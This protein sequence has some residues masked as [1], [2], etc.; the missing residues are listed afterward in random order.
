MIWGKQI[1]SHFKHRYMISLFLYREKRNNRQICLTWKNESITMFVVHCPVYFHPCKQR[2]HYFTS[3]KTLAFCPFY[4]ISRKLLCS[5]R[6]QP[7]LPFLPDGEH[8]S[9]YEALWTV[10]SAKDFPFRNCRLIRKPKYGGGSQHIVAAWYWGESPEF[11]SSV[12][13][14]FTKTW[15]T[16]VFVSRYFSNCCLH[17]SNDILKMSNSLT[18]P[19]PR[20]QGPSRWSEANNRE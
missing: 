7:F 15:P 4:C 5:D 11:N 19:T 12:F 6:F 9:F 18:V 13:C 2:F 16:M 10:W 8:W 20:F 14:A 1:N 17:N 3:R